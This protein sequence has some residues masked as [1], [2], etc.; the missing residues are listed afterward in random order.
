MVQLLTKHLPLGWVAL[1][2]LAA[3][4]V[5]VEK[6]ASAEA[7]TPLRDL[8]VPVRSVNWVHLHPGHSHEAAACLYAV[9]GQT[10]ENLF[11]LQIDPETGKFR[12]FVSPGAEH[13]LPH[14]NAYEPR[15]TA[16]CGCG[17]CGPSAVLRSDQ[18]CLG[19][20]GGH[21]SRRSHLPLPYGRG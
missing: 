14:G 6:A 11:V 13:E 4:S 20:S 15:G 1:A 3:L 8:G 17:L 21:S 19:G 2:L 7:A 9:M 5:P 18:R 16:L 12:Q 10:A